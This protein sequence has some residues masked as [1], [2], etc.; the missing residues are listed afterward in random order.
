MVMEPT[1]AQGVASSGLEACRGEAVCSA[2]R[3][4]SQVVRQ[5]SAKALCLFPF[6]STDDRSS[7]READLHCSASPDQS[8]LSHR[9]RVRLPAKLPTLAA[10][11]YSGAER[12]LAV[13]MRPLLGMT[14]ARGMPVMCPPQLPDGPRRQE[15]PG[16]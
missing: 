3:R 11:R 10:R 2:S 15:S 9:D 14:S 13:T 8:Y 1:E 12:A 7:S 16:A 5:R 6:Q 4:R